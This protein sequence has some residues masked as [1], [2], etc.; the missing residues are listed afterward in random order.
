MRFCEACGQP[1]TDQDAF[2]YLGPDAHPATPSV[3]PPLTAP[4]SQAGEMPGGDPAA[5]QQPVYLP[6]APY[7]QPPQPAASQP[8]SGSCLKIALIV[9]GIAAAIVICLGV[10]AAGAWILGQ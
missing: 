9:I 8:A 2:S 3:I 4:P 10:V 5:G 7:F 6:P 1:V